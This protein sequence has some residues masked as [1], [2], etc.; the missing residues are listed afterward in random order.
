MCREL[1]ELAGEADEDTVSRYSNLSAA[2]RALADV[3]QERLV[4]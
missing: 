2:A 4:D 3:L 1:D